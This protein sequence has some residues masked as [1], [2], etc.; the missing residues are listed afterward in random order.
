[1]YKACA[2]TCMG[3]LRIGSTHPCFIILKVCAQNTP[4]LFLTYSVFTII[5]IVIGL[6]TIAILL[7]KN[8]IKG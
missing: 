8:Y 3:L 5:L 6:N 7:P 2:I 1:M 4:L